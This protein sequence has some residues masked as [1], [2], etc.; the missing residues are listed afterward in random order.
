MFTSIA[1]VSLSGTLE[2]KLHAIARAGFD[3]VEIFENDLITSPNSP[4]TIGRMVRDADLVCTVYQPFRDFEG[5]PDTL[6]Q[7]TFDRAERKFDTMQELGTDL[8]LVC[9]S[10]SPAAS[11]DR[12][13]IVADFHELGERAARRGLRI[14]YE[15]LAWGRHVNDHRDAWDIVRAAGH[16]S[17][18]LILDSFHSLARNVPTLSISGIDPDRIFLV[19]LADAPRLDMDLLQWSR[20]FRNFPGQGDLPIVDYHTALMDIGY[21]GP[22]SLEIFND[23][24]RTGSPT[25]IAVDGHRSLVWLGDAADRRRG[26]A[27]LPPP[28]QPAGTS[29]IEFA[30]DEVEGEELAAILRALGFI[31]VGQHR[32]KAVTRWVQGRGAQGGINL[33]INSEVEGFAHSHDLVHGASVCA[34][35]L[36]VPDA[37][38]ALVR[39][40]ALG[41]ERFSQAVSPGDI[42]IPSIR[43]VGGTLLY[44]V[45]E[46]REAEMWASEFVPIDESKSEGAGLTRIDH[47]AYAMAYDEFLSWQL[48]FASLLEAHKTQALE[49]ADP[50]G[51]VE[52]QAIETPGR[53]VR[54]T[55]NGSASQGTL[56]ARFLQG[57][58]GAGVQHIAFETDDI[59]A[60]AER[61]NALGMARL[62]IP[63]NYYEDL[64]ARFALEPELLTRMEALGIL[65]DNDARGEYFQLYSRAFAKRVFF[66]IVQ[67]RDYDGYGAANAPVRLA[68][69]ARFKED[70]VP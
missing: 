38:A 48:F 69:Q 31:A 29:F 17:V 39:A 62:P 60:T 65:Y 19:Q 30:A 15:A 53:K 40:E 35:G 25:Q 22:V 66:E 52:S 27:S 67:R 24:F 49:I 54:F 56:S 4:E 23:R 21:K 9:S 43:S 63:P 12:G 28:L 13:Q 20:H 47:I 41:M 10:I 61:L 37:Q 36:S 34:I 7:R 58:M 18:G 33:I 42:E 70:A 44:L 8:V 5:M 2:E 64:E 1:T 68:A 16:P 11:G 51:L 57:Y 45:E 55:L 50:K 3:G 59:F 26:Q 6:R 14:G 32:H 46:Q